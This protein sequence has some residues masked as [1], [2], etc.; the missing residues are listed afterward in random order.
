[1]IMMRSSWTIGRRFAA[2][3][4]PAALAL[5]GIAAIE[6]GRGGAGGQT[7]LALVAAGIGTA[8]VLSMW[9]MVHRTVSVPL[10]RMAASAREIGRPGSVR[11]EVNV[12]GSREVVELAEAMNVVTRAVSEERDRSSAA[13]TE[14]RECINECL[15]VLDRI[16]QGDPTARVER[17]FESELACGLVAAVNSA[18]DGVASLV[19]D[20]HEVAI[21]L[22]ES[23]GI[24]NMM[25][26]G[27]LSMRAS[28]D[29]KVEIVA[30]L[31]SVVNKLA[32]QM[33]ELA[34]QSKT[35]AAGDLRHRVAMSGDVSDAFNAM[36][37]ALTSLVS[38]IRGG[39]TDVANAS[40]EILQA[41]Q[42]D[43]AA[44]TEQAAQVS[45]VAAAG[46]ELAA[47]ARQV[48][49]HSQV[50]ADSSVRSLEAVKSG[51]DVSESAM[52]GMTSIRGSVSETARKIEGLGE[53]SQAITEIVTLI[54]GIADQTTLLSLNAA[55]EAARAGEA[56]KGF[57]VVAE[58]IGNLAERTTRSTHEISELIAGIQRE[59]ASCVMSMEESTKETERGSALVEEAGTRLKE[60][61]GAFS[62]VASAAEE[63]SLSSQQQESASQ[64]ISHSMGG[65]DGAVK[66]SV[67][68]AAQVAAA[69]EQ[70]SRLAG[71]LSES[72]KVFQLPEHANSVRAGG[73]DQMYE[74]DG[75]E[76]DEHM[77]NEFAGGETYDARR[78]EAL[79]G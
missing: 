16:E 61:E 62:E 26:A 57:A 75:C 11:R 69:A 35:I 60:I 27:D 47:T 38:H 17:E 54:E 33:L 23:F 7:S 46:R 48:S 63:I 58:A 49:E 13:A 2:I 5:G 67:A 70:L 28:E 24:I 14:L 8:A 42:R 71:D 21:G 43:A 32:E 68:A 72:V 25:I 41:S 18:A 56:G 79:E 40:S 74:G 30:K 50:I 19:D 66:E 6:L 59:T 3:W 39:A 1:M 20:A 10:R 65:I 31:G 37:D 52:L 9:L 36:S 15:A 51:I 76:E 44:A 34:E 12:G 77:T 22:A 45:Q 78:I 55:I 64:E 73:G 4:I 29:S 53:S